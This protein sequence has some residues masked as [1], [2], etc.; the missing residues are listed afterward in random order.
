MKRTIVFIVI[1][2]MSVIAYGQSNLDFEIIEKGKAKGWQNF[3]EGKYS[4]EVDTVISQ[5]GKKS[6]YIGF[7]EGTPKFKA[8]SYDIPAIYQGN[9]IKLTGYI[10]TENVTDGYAGLWMRLDPSVGFDNMSDRGVKGTTDWKKYEVELDLKSSQTQKIVVGGLLVGKG[11]MWLDNLKV[12]IDG[13]KLNKV[14]LK[15]LSKV[16]KDTI[17]KYGS[18]IKSIELNEQKTKDLKHLCLIWGF[19]KYYH[20]NIAKGEYNWD[21]ELFRILPKIIGAK[22]T[23]ERDKYLINWI[24]KLGEYKLLSKKE[25][26]IL[27]I[28]LRADLVWIK[29]SDYSKKLKTVLVKIKNAKR[30]GKNYY[31]GMFPN[32]QNFDFKNESAYPIKY[33]DAGYRLLAL[34]RYWNIIQYYFPYKNLIGE[35]WKNVLEEF[36]PKIINAQNELEYKLAILELVARI[37]DTHAKV[38]S[39]DMALNNYWGIN[40]PAIELDFVEN[41]AVI[42][43]YYDDKLGKQTGLIK[44]DNIIKINNKPVDAIIKEQL[45]YIPASN[46]P[47]QLRDLS[48]KILRTN[49]TLLNLE[50][51]R[52]GQVQ[53]KSVK[54]YSAKEVNIY[55]KYQQR[56]TC[57]KFINNEI[58][59]LYLGSI[60]NS[61]L[62]G[63][64]EKIKGTKG[65]IIDLRCYP[66]EFVVFTLSKYLLPQKIQFARFSKGSIKNAGRFIFSKCLEVGQKNKDYYKGKVIILVNEITQSQAEYTAMAL[67]VTPKAIVIGSTTAGADG[68]VSSFYL[69]GN[70]KTAISGIGVYYP[71]KKETQRIGIVPDI[72]ITPTIQGI[73]NDKDELLEKA[74]EC[75]ESK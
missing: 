53:V 71:D 28:K 66:S 5:K 9:K 68:N 50:F 35:D 46:Y 18:K 8:W 29:N 23:S 21:F 59:Y 69:P 33:P 43:G 73:I 36:I 19:L 64:F 57:F 26:E 40:Y 24:Q 44:G 52:N 63:I 14:P 39:W 1:C 58:A 45:K 74:I 32:A 51:I 15:E 61:Y 47:A 48:T 2:L 11:K 7:I 72:K 37:H 25:K 62:P 3:G 54:T 70:I 67:R 56:D 13:K 17:F 20:P 55:K 60:K 30:S 22:N 12:T 31:V 27:D 34:Y 16:E 38:W 4:L 6:G 65:L 42:T 49:D 41:K 10:K 75:I